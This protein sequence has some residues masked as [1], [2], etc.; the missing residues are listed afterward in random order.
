MHGIKKT[1]LT[2]YSNY[3]KITEILL[4]IEEHFQLNKSEN[5]FRL[6]IQISV[7]FGI[8]LC[9]KNDVPVF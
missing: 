8:E 5:A 9:L 2:S 3:K 6:Y 4:T 1:D 7:Y